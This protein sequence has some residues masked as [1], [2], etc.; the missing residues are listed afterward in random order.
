MAFNTKPIDVKS[1]YIPGDPNAISANLGYTRGEDDPVPVIKISP[2]E[3][4]NFIPTDYGY[5]S[6]FGTNAILDVP[7]LVSRCQELILLQSQTLT[8]KLVALC[9]DGVWSIDPSTNSSVWVHDIV[10]LLANVKPANVTVEGTSSPAVTETSTLTF[11]NLTA[12]QT[13]SVAGRIYTST[14]VSSA[15]QVATA[16]SGGASPAGVISGTLALWTTTLISSGVVKYTSTTANASVSNIL[17]SVTSP[18]DTS[19]DPL[20]YR[21]WSVAK[22]SNINYFYNKGRPNIVTANTALVIGY[23]TPSFLTMSGQ[24]GVF[25]A[26]GRLGL[27]DSTGSIS[28]SSVFDF[29]DWTPSLETLAGFA[30]FN[31]V[32]GDIVTIKKHGDGFIIYARK[33]ITTVKQSQAVTG[34]LWEA[35]P[36][37]L[38][39][40]IRHP[41]EVAV[42]I[43]TMEH[44]VYTTQ[45][46]IIIKA[47]NSFMKQH[48]IDN[49]LTPIVDFLRENKEAVFIKLIQGRYLFFSLIN[50]NY[51]DGIV[52]SKETTGSGVGAVAVKWDDGHNVLLSDGS[53]MMFTGSRVIPSASFNISSEASVPMYPT[54]VGS[55]VYDIVYEKWGKHRGDHQIVLGLTPDNSFDDDVA[56]FTDFG[57][58]AG[59]LNKAGVI[60]LFDNS[61]TDSFIRYGKIGFHR[62]GFT[63]LYAASVHFRSNSTGTLEVENSINNRDLREANKLVTTFSDTRIVEHKS[64][65]SAR[66][67][68]L[69]VRGIWD[70]QYME[71]SAKVSGRR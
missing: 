50:P 67:H 2:Y 18:A 59:I 69:T 54:F 21:E 14:G 4:Y 43:S 39:G 49:T 7:V 15:A 34:L 44:F 9:E 48:E 24:I 65:F 3:G 20:V 40:G 23:I 53:S 51:I 70:L 28:W 31:A 41:N 61:P 5:R 37:T 33:S 1:T 47:F 42:G 46:L 66:W 13:V 19:Y 22:M 16:M 55:L 25:E 68:T 45:G 36:I 58:N 64:S 6:Y 71:V 17:I 56:G 30:K 29:T 32:I 26:G 10:Y 63:A 62:T 60:R 52:S 12:G 57:M 35:T 27:W 8:N 11:T 38:T